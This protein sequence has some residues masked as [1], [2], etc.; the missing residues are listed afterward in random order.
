MLDRT[1]ANGSMQWFYEN[2]KPFILGEEERTRAIPGPRPN[3][4]RQQHGS[5][6]TNA[7]TGSRKRTR[8]PSASGRPIPTS[9]GPSTEPYTPI[10]PVF[11]YSSGSQIHFTMAPPTKGFFAG[12]F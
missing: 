8:A 9:E 4:P 5:R 2:G 7:S 1:V 3:L 10:P 12:A 11:S 6:S